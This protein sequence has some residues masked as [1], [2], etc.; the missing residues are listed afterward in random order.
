MVGTS[1]HMEGK[2]I[3]HPSK[4]PFQNMLRLENVGDMQEIQFLRFT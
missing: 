4:E 3:H 1:Q 2:I